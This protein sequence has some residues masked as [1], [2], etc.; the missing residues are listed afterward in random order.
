MAYN[1]YL[2]GLP[3]AATMEAWVKRKPWMDGG[4][5]I[6]NY[7]FAVDIGIDTTLRR[8]PL[9]PID[10]SRFIVYWSGEN[11]VR[12]MVPA[13]VDD[14]KGI[15]VNPGFAGRN[16]QVM[17]KNAVAMLPVGH[18]AVV[19]GDFVMPEVE[20][21]FATGDLDVIP[22]VY[23]KQWIFQA[24]TAITAAVNLLAGYA[25]GTT[26]ILI[27]TISVAFALR[28]GETISITTG[29]VAAYYLISAIDYNVGAGAGADA[30]IT[31]AWPL[32][33]AIINNDV[34]T[35]AHVASQPIYFP[36]DTEWYQNIKDIET[37]VQFDASVPDADML[38][39][40][41]FAAAGIAANTVA[42]VP[43]G[44]F[45]HPGGARGG[46]GLQLGTV[47]DSGD[48]I[49]LTAYFYDKIIRQRT[50]GFAQKTGIARTSA[51]VAE[52]IPVELKC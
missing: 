39:V 10:R 9:N 5:Q 18:E 43:S 13:H 22:Q 45:T 32:T 35:T 49:T 48:Q 12:P 29:G 20:S 11:I 34:I 17:E 3:V 46:V 4:S 19:N 7:Q 25:A 23:K 37:C 33:A 2:E 51:T 27:D 31:L 30:L 1:P 14:Y 8:F 16:E 44:G 52:L 24:H 28:P 21:A 47:L 36:W 42:I 15:T 50:V 38:P 26:Q 6:H 41:A 40:V